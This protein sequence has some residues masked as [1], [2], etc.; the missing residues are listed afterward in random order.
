GGSSDVLLN[1]GYEAWLKSVSE[2]PASWRII[3]VNRAVPITAILDSQLRDRVEQLFTG[4]LIVSSPSVGETQLFGFDGATNG[5]RNI[6][7]ITVWFSE[8]RIRDISVTYSGGITAGPHSYG[9]SNPL[10]QSD[11]LVLTSG[12]VHRGSVIRNSDVSNR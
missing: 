9:V 3:K 10:S 4:S 12:S 2:T 7:K 6:E 8:F 5:L 1:Q 11:T